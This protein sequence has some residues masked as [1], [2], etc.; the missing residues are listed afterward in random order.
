MVQNN[1]ANPVGALEVGEEE[2]PVFS[3]GLG[4]GLDF[5]YFEDLVGHSRTRGGATID[6]RGRDPQ[7][8]KKDAKEGNSRQDGHNG[9]GEGGSEAGLTHTPIVAGWYGNAYSA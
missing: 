3:N 1:R 8:C 5:A 7:A 2:R 9:S 6:D 4:H